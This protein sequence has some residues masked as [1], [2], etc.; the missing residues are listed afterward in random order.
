ML[1]LR[2]SDSR[3]PGLT[4]GPVRDRKAE[5]L[6]LTLGLDI[7]A[8]AAALETLPAGAQI[9]VHGTSPTARRTP[10]T[11]IN[12]IMEGPDW[13]STAI[14]L[15]WDDWGGFY[16]HVLPPVADK[17]GYRFRV[18]SLVIGPYARRGLIDHQTLSFDAINKFIE[19][20]FLDGQRLDPASDGRPDPRPDVRENN[21]G[22]GDF[23]A[24]FDFGQQPLPPLILPLHPLPGPAST[25]GG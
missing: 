9:T 25:P 10:P 13:D 3:A 6:V 24:D 22:L 4:K 8:L 11:W 18:P 2:R 12:T 21:P 16:D 7:F 5:R 14:F 19:D 1:S 15:V 20:D 23:T 17:N